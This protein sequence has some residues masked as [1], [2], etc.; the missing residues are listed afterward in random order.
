MK[1]KH[2]FFIL[3]I[4]FSLSIANS[5][6]QSKAMKNRC[7]HFLT[8]D[9]ISDGQDYIA[10][11][12]EDNKAKFHTTFFGGTTYRVVVCSETIRKN[13]FFKIYDQ[14][15]NLLFSNKEHENIQYWNFKFNSSVE[16]LIEVEIES[17][18]TL[19]GFVMLLIGFKE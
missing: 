7:I 10:E 12:N 11:L 13:I 1:T 18:S 16:C 5:N 3:L 17:T 4:C 14:E 2:L 15:K 6:A 19:E 8:S 9:Y